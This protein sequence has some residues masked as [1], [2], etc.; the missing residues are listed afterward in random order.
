MSDLGDLPKPHFS[1]IKQGDVF[2]E[3]KVERMILYHGSGITGIGEFKAAEETTL[4]Q[5]LYLTSQS[6]TGKGYALRRAKSSHDG[7]PTVY[8]VEINNLRFADFTKPETLEYF[9]RLLRNRL[10]EE[11][12]KPGLSWYGEAAMRKTL[13]IIKQRGFRCLRDLAWNHQ[14]LTTEIVKKQG[15]NDRFYLSLIS[16]NLPSSITAHP[17]ISSSQISQYP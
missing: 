12:K 7:K 6:E 13:D 9:S 10:E 2:P 17:S 3:I 15:L 16:L 4:G 11:L 8:E 14:G 1:E 5:G